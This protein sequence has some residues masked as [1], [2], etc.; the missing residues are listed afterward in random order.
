M[1]I[2]IIG[3]SGAG[4]SAVAKFLYAEVKKKFAH[5][6]LLDGDLLREI[7]GDDL[8]HTI[9]GRKKNSDRICALCKALDVQGIHVICAVLSIFHAAQKWNRK[10]YSKYFE[11]YLEVPREELFKRDFKGLYK[12]AL[13]G[14]LKNVVGVDIDFP[15]PHHPDL[16]IQN[17]GSKKAKETAREIFKAIG[18]FLT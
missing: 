8:G 12:K 16:V 4:K 3:M 15:T 17:Y 7:W 18:N 2:W 10:N 11:V 6:I 13:A 9:E 14:K 5:T 1:V